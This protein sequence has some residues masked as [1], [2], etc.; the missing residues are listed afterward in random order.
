MTNQ[1]IVD[2]IEDAIIG[3][4]DGEILEQILEACWIVLADNRADSEEGI[5]A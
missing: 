4:V 2:Q 5:H 3:D 1:D